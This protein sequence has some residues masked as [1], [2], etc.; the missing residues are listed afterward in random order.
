[1][2][3]RHSMTCYTHGIQAALPKWRSLDGMVGVF[4]Q[5]E[6]HSG[7]HAYYLSPDP[8]I[9]IFFNDVSPHIRMSDRSEDM[10]RHCR[11][12]TRALYVPAGVPMWTSF[13]SAHRFSHLDL[14]IEQNRLLRFLTPSIG[15]S[16]ALATVR[17]PVEIQN[18][19]AIE[20]LAALLVDELSTPKR[21]GL[22]AESLVGSIA[23][24]LLEIGGDS[25]DRAI[26]GLTPAQLNKLAARMDQA[27]EHRLTVAEM[28]ATV[29]L[30]E[31][32]FASVFKKTTG[33]TPL[34]WQLCHRI[35]MA[36]RFLL[37]GGMSLPDIAARLGFSDQA[38]LTRAFRQVAG[39]TPAA[40][41]RMQ[42]AG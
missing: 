13:T 33:Q 2:S 4:W 34:Q 7:A 29:G 11:P 1:M 37:Q 3:F 30:S 31:S 23:A 36:Q 42:Q 27:S 20:A 6:G 17:R 35:D 38:H 10:D 25:D 14:H 12:M 19:D 9:M 8:R 16:A 26:G 39:E 5:A 24:G 40:W 18:V 32:W 22:Y 41:R 28:A 21:H 15:R